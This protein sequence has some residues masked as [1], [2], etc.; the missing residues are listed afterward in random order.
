LVTEGVAADHPQHASIVARVARF[1]RSAYARAIAAEGAV[2]RREVDFV[3]GIDDGV[4]RTVT[5]RGSMD[6]VVVWPN[7][8]VDVV[9]YKSAR[10]PVGARGAIGSTT[11]YAFQLDV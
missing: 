6:L 9:D 2:L 10:E 1:V 8:G 11:S 7:G 3:L 4:G 5:L